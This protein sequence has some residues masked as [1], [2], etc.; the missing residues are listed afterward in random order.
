MKLS[1]LTKKIKTELPEFERQKSKMNNIIIKGIKDQD[2]ANISSKILGKVFAA[3][4]LT[5]IVKSVTQLL[6]EEQCTDM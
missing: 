6:A 2:F 4:N 1:D 3:D 5:N